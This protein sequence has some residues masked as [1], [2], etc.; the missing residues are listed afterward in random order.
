MPTF[1]EMREGFKT[2]LSSTRLQW[3]TKTPS[4]SLRL[5]NVFPSPAMIRLLAFVCYFYWHKIVNASH[6]LSSGYNSMIPFIGFGFLDN[7][8]MIIAGD[9]IDTTIGVTLGISTMAAAGFGMANLRFC[10]RM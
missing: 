1:A 8:L 9:Y 3:L 5:A 7:A 6:R 10:E 2:K 4:I